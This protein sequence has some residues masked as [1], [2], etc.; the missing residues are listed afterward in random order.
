VGQ[1]MTVALGGCENDQGL[2][3]A[4]GSLTQ[5]LNQAIFHVFS[6]SK[7]NSASLPAATT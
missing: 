5:G 2:V 3:L 1:W 7:K 4:G 6:T